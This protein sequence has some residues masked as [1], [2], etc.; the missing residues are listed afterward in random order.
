MQVFTQASPKGTAA[1][2]SMRT[3]A[4]RMAGPAAG[5]VLSSVLFG[6]ARVLVQANRFL[7]FLFLQ[8]IAKGAPEAG[9]GR[10]PPA[11]RS[12]IDLEV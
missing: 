4:H 12:L 7:N 11:W 5:N 10:D 8:P 9:G 3:L 2:S 6:A 1:Q